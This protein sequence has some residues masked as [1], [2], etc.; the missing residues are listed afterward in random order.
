MGNMCTFPVVSSLASLGT[1]FP[2]SRLSNWEV[3]FHSPKLDCDHTG[4]EF[5]GWACPVHQ[6]GTD[7]S[8]YGTG[9]L[10][11]KM[12]LSDLEQRGRATFKMSLSSC[13]FSSFCL[14]AAF[15]NA[16]GSLLALHSGIIPLVLKW[17]YGMP[18]YLPFVIFL[19]PIV[20][21]VRCFPY[22]QLTSVQSLFCIWSSK[23]L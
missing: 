16:Q 6:D 15:S 23:N 2:E 3:S 20:L 4:M 8:I 5:V 13:E 9:L 14:W 19:L 22:T 1:C 11:E 18:G 17:P 12:L 7:R 21:E 10:Q